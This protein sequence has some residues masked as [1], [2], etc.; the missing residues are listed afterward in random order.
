VG[1]LIYGPFEAISY[2]LN[3]QS[4]VQILLKGGLERETIWPLLN[5]TKTGLERGLKKL[6]RQDLLGQ[7]LANATA[8]TTERIDFRKAK[9]EL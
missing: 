3:A 8:K 7:V 1:D 9:E 4:V 5:V 6:R 2:D